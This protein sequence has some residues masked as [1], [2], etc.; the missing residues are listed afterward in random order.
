M[1]VEKKNRKKHQERNG[2]S[3]EVKCRALLARGHFYVQKMIN[4]I[5]AKRGQSLRLLMLSVVG[6]LSRFSK[7]GA[8][9]IAIH[10]ADVCALKW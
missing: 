4:G 2:K 9:E 1:C 7:Q 8:P 10:R 6:L 3:G 5:L